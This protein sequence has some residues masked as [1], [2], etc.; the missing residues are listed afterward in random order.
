MISI[1]IHVKSYNPNQLETLV[2]KVTQ[3]IETFNTI[4]ERES[5]LPKYYQRKFD[6]KY[7]VI[8]SPHIHKKS[9]EQFQQT[10]YHKYIQ[11]TF[12]SASESKPFLWF[13]N[14]ICARLFGI[15]MK[16]SIQFQNHL[17]LS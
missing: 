12:T 11:L 13:L 2:R 4:S 14:Q 3:N 9:R 7:T 15:Q 17:F 1:K 5:I 6:R 10:I 8:R 16:A